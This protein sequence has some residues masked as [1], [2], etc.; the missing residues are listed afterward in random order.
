MTTNVQLAEVLNV[1]KVWFL[2]LQS[3]GKQAEGPMETWPTAHPPAGNFVGSPQ[4]IQLFLCTKAN[5]KF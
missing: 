3:E 4:V 5:V 2:L 1:L